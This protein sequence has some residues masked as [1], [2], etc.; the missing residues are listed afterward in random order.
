VRGLAGGK[1]ISVEVPVER[2][3][4]HSAL[5]RI[6]ARAGIRDLSDRALVAADAAPTRRRS[7]DV[8]L[9]HG[10]VSPFTAFI[11]VDAAS[12]TGPGAATV[13]PVAVP[14]PAGVN[15]D[16]TVAPRPPR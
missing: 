14:V 12:Q 7:R 1:P 16:R 13:V 11:A 2:I 3:A 9:R 6:W 8:A 5:T 10:L 15:Y 4:P